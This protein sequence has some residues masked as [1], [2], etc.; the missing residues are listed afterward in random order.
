[1]KILWG[2]LGY[3]RTKIFPIDNSFKT[4]EEARN[5]AERISIEMS[6]NGNYEQYLEI[7]FIRNTKEKYFMIDIIDG[8]IHILSFDKLYFEETKKF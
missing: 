6:Q 7:I 8:K 4:K 3:L 5:Y 1:M 2:K